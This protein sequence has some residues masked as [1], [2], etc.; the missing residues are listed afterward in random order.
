MTEEFDRSFN[1]HMRFT[2]A[3]RDQSHLG[4]VLIIAAYIDDKLGRIIEAF[5]VE[6]RV[7]NDLFKGPQA[8][9][10]SFSSRIN[11]AYAMA[12]ISERE[13]TSIS[14]IRKIRNKF[15]HNIDASFEDQSIRSHLDALAWAVGN[16][17]L[18]NSGAFFVFRMA[19]ER[20]GTQLLNRVDHVQNARLVDRVWDQKRTDYDPDY[21]PY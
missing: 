12:L 7:R 11:L 20:I 9:I 18:G 1:E 15:A 21:D 6:G 5:L 14:A 13:F 2:S 10:G 3:L 16:D 19:A 17:S 8:P 4:A